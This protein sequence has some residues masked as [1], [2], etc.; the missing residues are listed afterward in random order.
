MASSPI[1][2]FLKWEKEIPQQL[3]FRQPIGG[4]WKT[5]TYQQAGNEIRK[6]ASGLQSLNLPTRS[7]VAIV[8]KNCAHWIMAD[9]A[10]MMTG[11]I[12]VPLYANSSAASIKQIL[13]HSES[14][15]IF[16]GKLDDYA[17]QKK[18]IPEHVTKISISLFGINEGI[19]WEDVLVKQ[20]P[21]TEFSERGEDELLTIMY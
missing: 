15:V 21:L 1:E 12:S 20:K 10:I 9:L 17:D 11:H 8:S 7:K 6:I 3:F 16:V 18:G 2:Q 5:W 4:E 19:T 14:K 13:E